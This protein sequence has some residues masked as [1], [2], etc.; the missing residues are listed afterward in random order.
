MDGAVGYEYDYKMC[1]A[2]GLTR[3]Y[4]L[5]EL[6]VR[7]SR[8]F[9]FEFR[10]K[11]ILKKLSSEEEDEL[12]GSETFEVC[13]FESAGEYWLLMSGRNDPA[14]ADLLTIP[15]AIDLEVRTV[16][17]ENESVSE[18]RER[19]IN[20]EVLVPLHFWS[21]TMAC[22]RMGRRHHGDVLLCML[23][24][25]KVENVEEVLALMPLCVICISVLKC[26]HIFH[27]HAGVGESVAL[28]SRPSLWSYC[29][30]AHI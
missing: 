10:T 27:S 22:E 4:N 6:Q 1:A 18:A 2:F 17:M 7:N 25:L 19:S 29:H 28:V 21:H 20:P 13:P 9:L 16:Q 30:P 11:F 14:H 15:V 12:M 3:S 8:W 24:R 26:G 5:K 23:P